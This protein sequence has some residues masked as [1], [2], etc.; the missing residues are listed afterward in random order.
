LLADVYVELLGER[1]ATLGLASA[2]ASRFAE[3]RT[4]RAAS[5]VQRQKP[6]PSRLSAEDG[7][8][9]AAFIQTLGPGAVWLIY[10]EDEPKS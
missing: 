10:G 7:A 6:L 2:A 9:H 3:N 5:A 8:A 1:Q 4:K